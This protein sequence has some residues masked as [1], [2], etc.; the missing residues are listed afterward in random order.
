M[1]FRQFYNTTEKS[2]L[3]MKSQNLIIKRQ[4]LYTAICILCVMLFRS[5][6]RK[7]LPV[8]SHFPSCWRKEDCTWIGICLRISTTRVYSGQLS[9]AWWLCQEIRE[10]NIPMMTVSM[11]PRESKTVYFLWSYVIQIQD[12]SFLLSKDKLKNLARFSLVQTLVSTSAKPSKGFTLKKSHS[13]QQSLTT[14]DP[15][16]RHYRQGSLW[17]DTL[18]FAQNRFTGVIAFLNTFLLWQYESRC[19]ISC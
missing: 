19:P 2:S 3:K 5:G 9:S 7:P 15:F 10:K 6:C 14:K 4:N 8:L 12:D 11:Q 17:L 16:V 13:R 18:W 1:Y